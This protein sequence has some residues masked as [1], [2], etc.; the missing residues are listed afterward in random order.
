ML[1]HTVAKHK[2]CP[3]SCLDFP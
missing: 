2:D 3:K 1:E